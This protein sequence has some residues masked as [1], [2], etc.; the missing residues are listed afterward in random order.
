MASPLHTIYFGDLDPKRVVPRIETRSREARSVW[1]LSATRPLAAK[2]GQMPVEGIAGTMV[3]EAT[4]DKV[5]TYI[6]ICSTVQT[7]R[8]WDLI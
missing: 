8:L 7:D 4:A 1:D 6:P 2:T 3:W 5:S